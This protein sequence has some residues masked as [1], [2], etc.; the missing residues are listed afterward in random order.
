MASCPVCGF[1]ASLGPADAVVALRSFP[2]RFAELAGP[3]AG[4][5]ASEAAASGASAASATSA[6]EGR[7]RWAV[8]AAEAG[9]AAEA[10]AAIS[11]DLRKVLIEDGPALATTGDTATAVR[12]GGDPATAF[13][14]LRAAAD[15][16]AALVDHQPAE[17]WGRT[18]T[19]PEGPVT[20]IDLVRDAVHAG[21]H[22]LRQAE[23]A[24][25]A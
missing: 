9:Q 13:D 15:A 10:I 1:D 2:R 20:A 21:V 22:H 19:R 6:T 24:E 5:E 12:H 11:E 16:T 17:A 14:R 4:D 23:A 7:Q 25:S 3:E 8:V 18:G